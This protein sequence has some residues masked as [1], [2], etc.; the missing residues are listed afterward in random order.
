MKFT[1]SNEEKATL[2]SVLS[3]VAATRAMRHERRALQKFANK[4]KPQAI[5]VDLN[6]TERGL[7]E[8]VVD[9]SDDIIEK[10]PGE[11]QNKEM[12]EHLKTVVTKMEKTS[13]N[14]SSNP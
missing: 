1:F 11:A 5:W 6:P 12:H 4:F 7:L 9:S 13:E 10:M 14:H 3:Y 8:F 2:F